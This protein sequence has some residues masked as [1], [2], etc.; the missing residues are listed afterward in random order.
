MGSAGAVEQLAGRVAA[1]LGDGKQQV[2]GGDELIFEMAGFVE[3]A[4]E[5]LVEGLR[6]V[7]SGLPACSLGHALEHIAGFRDDGVGLNAALFE[8]W[9]DDPFLLL[10]QS[11]EQME[12][13]HHLTAALLGN[14]LGLLNG[15]LGLLGEFI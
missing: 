9:A 1:L 10:G 12:G 7:H 2:L 11:D 3:G 13:K 4:L 5:Y 8:D 6:E 15:L 14:G